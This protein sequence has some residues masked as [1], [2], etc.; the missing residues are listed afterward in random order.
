MKVIALTRGGLPDRWRRQSISQSGNSVR[1]RAGR[2]AEVS[3]G[4]SSGALSA[5]S[6]GPN[7]GKV[8]VM[9]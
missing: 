1:Q 9:Q 6:E 8:F 3:R 5:R 4:H 2:W 7:V